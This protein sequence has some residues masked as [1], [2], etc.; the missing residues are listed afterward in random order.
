MYDADGLVEAAAGAGI[1]MYALGGMGR[2]AADP[3]GGDEREIID[4]AD[5]RGYE[6]VEK[7][8]DRLVF[9]RR[10]GQTDVGSFGG[11]GL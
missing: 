5:E 10:E 1:A 6:L 4:F 9:E 8:G 3:G 2:V 11:L 7:S